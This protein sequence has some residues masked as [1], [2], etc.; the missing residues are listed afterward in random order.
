MEEEGDCPLATAAVATDP[1]AEQ[2]P[3]VEG[4][5]TR[6]W[7]RN[8][9]RRHDDE[10]ATT[11][12]MWNGCRRGDFFEGCEGAAGEAPTSQTSTA[13]SIHLAG[14]ASGQKR[15]GERVA[16]TLRTPS[17]TGMQ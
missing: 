17:G 9:T 3:E 6:N 5:R 13:R 8:R 1:A 12:A 16:E 2:S 7:K 10:G 14:S 11:T 15:S 4:R